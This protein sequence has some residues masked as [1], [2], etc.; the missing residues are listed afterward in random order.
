[1]KNGPLA[2]AGDVFLAQGADQV[3]GNLLARR[4]DA[5]IQS[6][7]LANKFAPTGIAFQFDEEWPAGWGR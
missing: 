6:W 2:G 4:F 1:M 7:R 3:G 5:V